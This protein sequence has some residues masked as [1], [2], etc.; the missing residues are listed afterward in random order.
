MLILAPLISKD[1]WI[2]REITHLKAFGKQPVSIVGG[3]EIVSLSYTPTSDLG[4]CPLCG[5]SSDL[6]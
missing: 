6:V 1:L 4:W 2:S 3:A 5:L